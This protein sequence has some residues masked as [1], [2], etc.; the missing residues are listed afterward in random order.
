MIWTRHLQRNQRVTDLLT[1]LEWF[2]LSGCKFIIDM[3]HATLYW[4][5]RISMVVAGGL[6]PN[7]RQGI[8][9]HHVDVGRS[10]HIKSSNEGSCS[11]FL[12]Y[13]QCVQINY[14]PLIQMAC[15]VVGNADLWWFFV[16]DI[17][18][19][20]WN[21]HEK[22]FSIIGPFAEKTKTSTDTGQSL[23]CWW[24]LC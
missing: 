9:I 7:R 4:F 8:C 20:L 22:P 6:A 19:S 5:S 13:P 23:G 2:V 24:L 15:V 10:P 14:P 18:F 21:T 17:G 1:S 16:V 3:I 11:P 12:Y